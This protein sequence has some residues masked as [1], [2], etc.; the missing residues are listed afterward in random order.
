M[1]NDPSESDSSFGLVSCGSSGRWGV[2]L[3]ESMDGTESLLALE[4]PNVYLVCS[5]RDRQVIGEALDYL[6][7]VHKQT[8]ALMLGRFGSVSVSLCCDKEDHKQCFLII[9]PVDACT[10]RLALSEEDTAMLAEALGKA[11]EHLPQAQ[12]DRTRPS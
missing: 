10:V 8:R 6:R 7:A 3:E 4:G 12:Q 9:G 5:L 11:Y 2:D 1:K